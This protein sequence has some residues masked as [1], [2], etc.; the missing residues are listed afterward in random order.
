MLVPAALALAR[1]SPPDA[2]L[3]RWLA[4]DRVQHAGTTVFFT[5]A[6]GSREAAGPADLR[7]FA[8]AWQR[9]PVLFVV[10][11]PRDLVVSYFFQRTK[12][13]QPAKDGRPVPPDLASFIRD[14]QFG[15]PRIIEVFNV[16]YRALHRAPEAMLLSYEALHEEPAGATRDAVRFLLGV[17]VPTEIA[18]RAAEHA[19]F[20][21][22][23]AL[24]LSDR[25][26]VKKRLWARDK[27]DPDSFKTRKGRIGSFRDTLDAADIAYIDRM[28]EERLAPE[29]RYR[30]PGD[31][32]PGFIRTGSASLGSRLASLWPRARPRAAGAAG[33]SSDGS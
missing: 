9:T 31:A 5:H 7:A 15:A 21:R 17:E 8:R 30:T 2:D 12:R 33:Q 3:E 27:S 26:A 25:F 20:D 11:D 13:R 28:I 4:S 32:P 29:L 22:M 10:R 14:P 24:E 6:L 19:S 18:R 23:R 1:G 16:W